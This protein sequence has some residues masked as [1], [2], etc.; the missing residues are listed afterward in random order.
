MDFEH[1]SRRDG[2]GILIVQIFD[3]ATPELADGGIQAPI[4]TLTYPPQPEGGLPIAESSI[5]DL[6][7]LRVEDLPDK[8]YVRAFF[9]D[10]LTAA[11][12]GPIDWGVWIGGYELD[13]GLRPS[14]IQEVRLTAGKGTHLELPLTALRYLHAEFD[15]AP[16]LTPLD[17][18]QGPGLALAFLDPTLRPN[19]RL[20]GVASSE[21]VAP[22]EGGSIILEG[23]FVGSGQIYLLGSINDFNLTS[24]VGQAPPG[25]LVSLAS[26]EAGVRTLEDSVTI[27]PR[28]YSMNAHVILR[29][30]VPLGDVDAGSGFACKTSDAGAEDA[31]DATEQDGE[32]GEQV[33]TDGAGPDAADAGV[34][35]PDGR[36]DAG[37]AAHDGGG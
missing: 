23:F 12:T 11:V 7:E 34:D 2:R 8:V 17:D 1:D 22:S 29:A 14:P 9:S 16:G 3:I 5:L 6:P 33:E 28:Q 25:S 24:G 10:N 26:S 4:R 18:G 37:D 32:A 31:S 35:A 13:Q 21:C 15:L 19:N 36:A 30:V 20:V 27:G